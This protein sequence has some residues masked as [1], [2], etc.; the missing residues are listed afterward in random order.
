MK[1][2]DLHTIPNWILMYKCSW[3]VLILKK[4]AWGIVVA[5]IPCYLFAPQVKNHGQ[6][7]LANSI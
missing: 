7:Y 4:E 6:N 3:H 2:F 5:G 1:M